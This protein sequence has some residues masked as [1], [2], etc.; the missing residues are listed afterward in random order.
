MEEAF[1]CFCWSSTRPC[2]QVP[3]DLEVTN[4][5]GSSP[6]TGIRATFLGSLAATLQG[7]RRSMAEEP[8][9]LVAFLLFIL[10]CFL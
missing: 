6:E 10:R 3:G 4:G 1:L 9:D 2:R 8:E 5:G 7:C